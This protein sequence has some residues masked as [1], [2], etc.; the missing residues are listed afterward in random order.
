MSEQ[1]LDQPDE[2][3]EVDQDETAVVDASNEAP[4]A[5]EETA[6]VEPEIDQDE[7]E[8]D[9]IDAFR[10]ELRMLPGDWY[11][12]HSYAG[13]EN[14]VKANL[15]SRIQS[16]NM[17]EFIFQVEVPMEEVVEMKNSVRK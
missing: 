7:T 2:A 17:E 10:R 13:Y 12:I 5:A 3:G 6:V 11:V 8:E 1:P 4:E 14:R 15:E 16:L 9:P